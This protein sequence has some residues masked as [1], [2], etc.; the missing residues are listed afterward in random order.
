MGEG[1]C[2]SKIAS[3]QWR[4]NF[5][6]E[7]SIC[8]AGPSGQAQSTRTAK[9]DPRTLSRK[10]SRKCTRECTRSVCTHAIYADSI[11]F[12]SWP[13]SALRPRGHMT[14]ILLQTEPPG[15]GGLKIGNTRKSLREGGLLHPRRKGLPR[16]S[17]TFRR[18]FC[19]GATLFCTSARGFSLPGSKRPF[20]TL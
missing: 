15:K 2:E 14:A 16:V 4:V 8:L 6:R 10:C 3:R 7:T 12:V 5:C 11:W 1:N 19:T 9:F 20:D 13:K 17:C 18:L